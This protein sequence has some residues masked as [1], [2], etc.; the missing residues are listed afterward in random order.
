[1]LVARR[2][3]GAALGVMGVHR[4]LYG[5]NFIALIL[6]SRNLLN[7]PAD[8]AAGLAT[9]AF[10]LGVSLAGNGLAIVATPLAHEHMSPARWVVVCLGIGAVSQLV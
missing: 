10:L 3:P 1:Y 9:F 5:A 7:D 2:T 4:F 8:A 6:M